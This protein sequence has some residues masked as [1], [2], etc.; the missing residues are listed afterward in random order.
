MKSLKTKIKSK[1]QNDPTYLHDAGGRA[2][3][4]TRAR[5][6]SRVR[7]DAP[8]RGD[9]GRGLIVK[10]KIELNHKFFIEKFIEYLEWLKVTSKGKIVSINFKRLKNWINNDYIIDEGVYWNNINK[11][12]REK[13]RKCIHNVTR[14]S[15]SRTI[16]IYKSEIDIIIQ[17]LKKNLK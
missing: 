5:S 13:C 1:F 12:I 16:V 11:V 4:P 7:V 17:E 8:E 10:K 9:R 3:H 15:H 6:P 14:D 2:S